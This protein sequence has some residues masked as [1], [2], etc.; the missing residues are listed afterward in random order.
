MRISDWS[1]DVCS[2]DLGEIVDAGVSV[3]ATGGQ[4]ESSRR[5]KGHID[6]DTSRRDPTSI[7]QARDRRSVERVEEIDLIVFE[8]VQESCDVETEHI[9]EEARLQADF[10]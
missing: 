9:V 7:D 6:F 3:G 10:K 1:S 5:L 2:S 8:L 4:R